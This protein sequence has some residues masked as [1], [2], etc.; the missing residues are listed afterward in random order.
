M[1]VYHAKYFADELTKRCAPTA[2]RSSRPRSPMRKWTST[3]TRLRRHYSLFARRSPKAQSLPT[4]SVWEKPSKPGILLAQ[5]WAERKRR[6]LVICPANLRKQWSQ[7]LADKFYLPSVI[8]ETRTFNEAIKRREP[9]SVP[10]GRGR[11]LLLPVCP[12]QRALRP[13]DALGTGC[14][15]RSPPAAQRLQ[16]EQ[17]NRQAIKAGRSAFQKVLLTATPLQNSLLELYGLVSIIDEY[18]FGDL[19]SFR[20]QFARPH[21]RRRFC[22][23]EAAP[24]A[25]MPANPAQDRYSNTSSTQTVTPWCRNSSRAPMNNGSTIWF[26]ITCSGPTLYAL[27]ASQ[28]Q[29]MTL[30][31]R[32]LLASSTYAISDTLEGLANRLQSAA[33]TPPSRCRLPRKTW[34]DN[35]ETLPEIE[36]E[37]RR[38]TKT[39]E[40]DQVRQRPAAHPRNSLQELKQE[41]ATLREFHA[42]AEHPSSRT[43]KAKSCSRRCASGFAAAED[44][45]KNKGVR[46]PAA[47][48]AHLHRVPPHP[49]ISLPDP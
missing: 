17:Q 21:R 23:T 13:A 12:L 27:P 32:K 14:D 29:L 19:K 33:Q 48:G 24:S 18:T 43:P 10:A 49:G 38:T 34:R 42:L 31:L 39:A 45:Q 1:T 9:Q 28:R 30:I 7:E 16:A 46:G 41:M 26:P 4:K 47:E 44:A 8:L 15:R 35:F 40:D 25:H 36:D 37:W 11:D 5:R 6:L 22:R 20:A 3:R 2:W